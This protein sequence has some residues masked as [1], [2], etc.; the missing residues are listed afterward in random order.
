MYCTK[1]GAKLRDGAKFCHVC[2]QPVAGV[3]PASSKAQTDKTAVK[4]EIKEKAMDLAKAG[5]KQI[6]A[7]LKDRD[8]KASAT[9][10]EISC[11]PDA[12]QNAFMKLLKKGLMVLILLVMLTFSLNAR[13][14]LSRTMG[15]KTVETYNMSFVLEFD[16][17][18]VTDEMFHSGK[19][20]H[21][22]DGKT[23]LSGIYGYFQ[24]KKEI[25]LKVR[26]LEDPG[27][28]EWVVSIEHGR[29]EGVSRNFYTRE[30]KGV[31]EATQS[32]SKGHDA[33]FKVPVPDIE[34]LLYLRI[35]VRRKADIG[36]ILWA[37]NGYV[38]E[39]YFAYG[40]QE[41][42]EIDTDAGGSGES[43]WVVPAAIAGALGAGGL[44]LKGRKKKKAA[45]KKSK[46]ASKDERKSDDEQDEQEEEED[47][48]EDED[49]K[50]TYEMRIRKDFGDTLS[51]G[52]VA[53]KVYARIV[54]IPQGGT[55]ATDP[56]LTSKISITGDDYLNVSGQRLAGDY[57]SASVEAPQ[58]GN[59]PDEAI[60]NFRLAGAG[61]AFT[62]RMHFKIAKSE[63]L[64]FQENLTLPACSDEVWRLPFAVRGASKSA[65]VEACSSVLDKY[66]VKIEPGEKD[67]LYYAVI[68]EKSKDKKEPGTW[69][70]LSL[71]IKV[72]DGNSELADSIPLYRF[73]LGLKFDPHSNI[74]CYLQTS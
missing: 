59:I 61:G 71:G 46:N 68:K 13:P 51:P 15:P 38:H 62:N 11:K 48:D 74:P 56:G 31:T 16:G 9:P 5:V 18:V 1:C 25:T 35:H 65:D 72:S 45:A 21:K 19:N 53:Q 40:G 4:T 37:G 44:A 2:G 28:D 3:K 52:D 42:S 17:A 8:I 39:Y 55:A 49:E 50:S 43:N 36:Y 29:G 58:T 30:T 54:R 69:E 12:A 60:V 27:N 67:C 10:G 32:L 63:I 66:D 14:E 64:F 20:Y 6:L 7:A 23:V 33:V 47:E 34:S 26:I 41:Y 73:H 24:N 70:Q 22:D 57:M